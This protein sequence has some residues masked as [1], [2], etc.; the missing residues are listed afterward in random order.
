M[1][2]WAAERGSSSFGSACAAAAALAAKAEFYAMMT[3]MNVELAGDV[4]KC[5]VSCAAPTDD[6]DEAAAPA[7]RAAFELHLAPAEGDVVHRLVRRPQR[8]R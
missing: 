2:I 3:G 7:R 5:V 4:A 6:A 1:P 8:R